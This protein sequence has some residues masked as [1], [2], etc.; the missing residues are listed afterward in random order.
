MASYMT[1]SLELDSSEACE[2][3]TDTAVKIPF[4]LNTHGHAGASNGGKCLRYPGYT[5]LTNNRKLAGAYACVS[6]SIVPL[7]S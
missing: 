6:Q 1:Q 5:G 4:S 3:I 2:F 7:Q